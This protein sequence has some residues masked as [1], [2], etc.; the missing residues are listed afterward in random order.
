MIF[1]LQKQNVGQHLV[2]IGF[3][4]VSGL[5]FKLEK[6]EYYLNYYKSLLAEEQRAERKGAGIWADSKKPVSRLF[7]EKIKNLISFLMVRNFKWQ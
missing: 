1:F 7:Y 3:G 4:S 2:S 5:D 6:D